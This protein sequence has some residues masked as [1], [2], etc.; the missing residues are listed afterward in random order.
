MFGI[1]RKKNSIRKYIHARFEDKHIL[2]SVKRS[3]WQ[4][5]IVYVGTEGDRNRNK[6]KMRKGT[7]ELSL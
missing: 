6:L 1:E 7:L 3:I 4:E 5:W 2:E